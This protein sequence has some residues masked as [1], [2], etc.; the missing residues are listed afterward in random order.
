MLNIVTIITTDIVLEFTYVDDLYLQEGMVT[1]TI[2]QQ[3]DS[4]EMLNLELSAEEQQ[5]SGSWLLDE[6]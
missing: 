1:S 4:Y 5:K 2:I 3:E 6:Q